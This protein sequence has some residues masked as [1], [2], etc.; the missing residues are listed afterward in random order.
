MRP[1]ELSRQLREETGM[2]LRLRRATVALSLTA[3]SSM[4]LIALYQVGIIKHLPEPPLRFLDADK[5]DASPEAYSRFETPDGILAM[6]N[7]TI[8]MG[9]AA[10]GSS[11]R[12]QE[13]PWIPLA[14]TAKVLFDTAQAI[15]LFYDQ[16]TKEHAFCSWCLLAAG[17]TLVT[18]PLILPET[19]AA[20]RSL[21]KRT[22]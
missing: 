22:R 16:K 3:V 9:L 21:L 10:M 15:R 17:T 14:L 6:G 8:T 7:Y 19:L 20:I 18:V 12:A 4:S 2:F 13:Q 11:H 1:E 5:V